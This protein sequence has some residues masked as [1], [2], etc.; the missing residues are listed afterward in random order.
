M[1]LTTIAGFAS[2]PLLTYILS[3]LFTIMAAIVY[4]EWDQSLIPNGAKVAISPMVGIGLGFLGMLADTE[5]LN[6]PLVISVVAYIKYGVAGFLLG[7]AAI[8]LDMM[9]KGGQSSEQII[10]KAIQRKARLGDVTTAKL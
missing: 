5:L 7:A 1:D 9:K 3:W 2:A 10:T 4:K 8:G 6:P